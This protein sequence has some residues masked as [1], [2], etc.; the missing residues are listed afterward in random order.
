MAVRRTEMSV[1]GGFDNV[2]ALGFST[3]S[4]DREY[5]LVSFVGEVLRIGLHKNQPI[6]KNRYYVFVKTENLIAVDKYRWTLTFSNV[7]GENILEKE[8][9]NSIGEIELNL[10]SRETI[11][12]LNQSATY[13][14]IKVSLLKGNTNLT[15]TPLTLRHKV[16]PLQFQMEERMK[17]GGKNAILGT[18][19]VNKV[20]ENYLKEYIHAAYI[21]EPSQLKSNIP[22][23]LLTAVVYKNIFENKAKGI[24]KQQND[25]L[26]RDLNTS[27]LQTLTSAAWASTGICG[28]KAHFSAMFIP[29]QIGDT[30]P[31]VKI[32]KIDGKTKTEV[33][34]KKAFKKL[35]VKE[36]V[37]IFNLLRFPKSNI[38]IC[39]LMLDKLKQQH[40]LFENQEINRA[41]YLEEHKKKAK[42][43][44]RCVKN[45]V[46]QLYQGPYQNVTP[47]PV[48]NME[49]AIAKSLFFNYITK[50]ATSYS[51]VK[52][53]KNKIG[54]EEISIQVLDIR[55][56]KPLMR[57]K[58]KQILIK[59]SDNKILARKV[60]GKNIH[61]IPYRLR[62]RGVSGFNLLSE[63][64]IALKRL[65]YL[66]PN[67][68]ISGKW[69]SQTKTAY[70]NYW[71][72]RDASIIGGVS[73]PHP[74]FLQY[75]FEDYYLSSRTDEKGV[76][77]VRIPKAFLNGKGVHIE[78]G[79]WEFPIVL[80]ALKR[81]PNEGLYRKELGQKLTNFSIFWEGDGVNKTVQNT[82]WD[83][84]ING[85][86]NFGWRVY[87]PSTD[88]SDYLKIAEKITIK[89]SSSTYS[90]LDTNL[91]SKFYD[92]K[93]GSAHFVLFG[94]QWC[95]PVWD[96]YWDDVA[97][98]Q[99]IT[100]VIQNPKYKNLHMHLVSYVYEL[101]GV[102]IYGGKG[103]GKFEYGYNYSSKTPNEKDTF[104][105]NDIG[106]RGYDLYAKDGDILFAIRG[107]KYIRRPAPT[108]KGWENHVSARIK[109]DAVKNYVQL[110]TKK[111]FEE[112]NQVDYL[113]L[114]AH[115]AASQMIILAGTI[116]A[117]AG[118]TGN[119][120]ITSRWPTHLHLNVGN[121]NNKPHKY[122]PLL[123]ETIDLLYPAN[124]MV[125]PN[126]DFPLMLP[127]YSEVTLAAHNPALCQFKK[128]KFINQCFA[129]AELKCPFMKTSEN[130]KSAQRLQV[131]LRY[132][133]QKPYINE[134]INK[135]ITERSIPNFK[136]KKE[137]KY[138]DPG[139]IDGSL[140]TF[141]KTNVHSNELSKG[142]Q[143]TIIKEVFKN[144][145]VKLLEVKHS[146]GSGQSITTWIEG[147]LLDANNKLNITKIN[148][149]PKNK[150]GKSRFAI[151]CFKKNNKTSA[152]GQ[153]L[154][155]ENY[156]DNFEMNENDWLVLNQIT[157]LNNPA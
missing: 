145:K 44:R 72:D 148:G 140:G 103:Y 73:T 119:L 113:H 63:A 23:E 132:L 5:A 55:S 104:W 68:T 155:Y 138:F 40:S 69:T 142:A 10:T 131:Q 67:A 29:K 30:D 87:N 93:E 21:G 150:V 12:I 26:A 66:A 135:P 125:L 149:L 76:L 37:Y 109:W 39:L 114:K 18:P 32:I 3:L 1:P 120:G 105:R 151:Y 60:S 97:T 75:I 96:K 16:L 35:K 124:E 19:L 154:N 13:C 11:Q 8:N 25:V 123:R 50:L 27:V 102:D 98:G 128:N 22:P 118:R 53:L 137:E 54:F 157:G 126:N 79:F 108:K 147:S 83:K 65:G 106:H 33:D 110:T 117:K 42:P 61:E 94:M 86:K 34:I 99:Q 85:T 77:K 57:A 133:N 31:F 71:K 56:G 14:T 81:T 153:L 59:G 91:L 136:V 78:V 141:S 90:Q 130:Q 82:E 152:G 28:L 17:I 116:V 80:E 64:Q 139:I 101:G 115:I 62:S 111:I 49:V 15:P 20:I 7:N 134:V 146:A 156:A 107:G 47:I 121:K 122:Y 74:A 38:K 41:T 58:V 144:S 95:Q 52:E 4:L 46:A 43:A 88:K 48:T 6:F 112:R 24:L 89:T 100:T 127:C 51:T 70:T 143:F 9:E 129:A 36:Q 92:G 2:N 84:H 45:I